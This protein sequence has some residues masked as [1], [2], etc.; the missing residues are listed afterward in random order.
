MNMPRT[1]GDTLKVWHL[2]VAV[3]LQSGALIS[4]ATW[5]AATKDLQVKELQAVDTATAI[6][7]K[8]MTV[9][10]QRID[11]EGSRIWANHIPNEE[12][13]SAKVEARLATIEDKFNTL[14]VAMTRLIVLSEQN[15]KLLKGN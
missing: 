4:G 12:R 6:Q 13:S 15:Q 1:L 7:V 14:N 11:M 2:L 3:I 5:W 10:I 9:D 8:A